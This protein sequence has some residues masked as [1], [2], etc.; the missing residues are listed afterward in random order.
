MY[1]SLL[2]LRSRQLKR[3]LEKPGLVYGSLLFVI[4]FV[5]IAF[6]W[7]QFKDP[8]RAMFIAAGIVLTI[9]SIHISRKDRLFVMSQLPVP[10]QQLFVEYSVLSLPFTLPCL[11]THQWY[12]FPVLLFCFYLVSHIR[13]V[14]KQRT[15]FPGL[16]KF[17]PVTAFELL[18]GL[19]KNYMVFMVLYI[20]ALAT[21]WL[22][23]APM[24]IMWF[25]TIA[26]LGCY[27]ECES[28][29][30]L[31][32]SNDPPGRFLIRKIRA[33][34]RRLLILTLPI[35]LIN[36]IIHPEHSWVGLLLLIIQL[37]LVTLGVA[38]KYSSYEPRRQ[39]DTGNILMSV[40]ALSS[41]IPFLMPLPLLFALK[42][43]RTAKANLNNYLYD[44]QP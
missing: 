6:I 27:Q 34:Y 25:F 28:Y 29:D 44:Q 23:L 24:F 1:F 35:L 15:V 12:L 14:L 11:F 2:R 39:L 43:F 31:T 13:I 4:S 17:I 32:I 26:T 8:L 7:A 5:I 10:E 20:A 33:H 30:M 3:Q 41:L 19:R 38:F 18:G 16:S 42:Y 36:M 37:V 21:S 22:M 9:L 40:I